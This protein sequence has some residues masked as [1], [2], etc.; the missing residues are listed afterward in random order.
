LTGED[1]AADDLGPDTAADSIRPAVG[2]VPQREVIRRDPAR[3]TTLRPVREMQEQTTVGEAYLRA[4]IRAQLALGLRMMLVLVLLL[5]SFP[6]ALLLMPRLRT[7]RVGGVP[8]AW[9]MLGVGVYPVFVL[10]AVAYVRRSERNEAD[11]VEL[12]TFTRTDTRP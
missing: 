12:V 8:V 2:G 9:P 5:G 10:L 1:A 4:L 6:L 11:F 7:F 3:A